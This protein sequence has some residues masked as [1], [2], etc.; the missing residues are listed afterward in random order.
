MLSPEQISYNILLTQ[1]ANM[2]FVTKAVN[3]QKHG[4]DKEYD[5]V[6]EEV[7]QIQD[8][9]YG[10]TL[11]NINDCLNDTEQ[12]F[13]WNILHGKIQDCPNSPT[14]LN[15]ILWQDTGEPIIWQS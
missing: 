2:N 15:Y 6:M 12:V 10:L 9:L 7:A 8:L 1:A 3:F 5:C 13:L 11:S 4:L 14:D